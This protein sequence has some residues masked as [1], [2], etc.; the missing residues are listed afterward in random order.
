MAKKP[1]IK[2]T[3][4]DELSERE[5]ADLFVSYE[6]DKNE[7][8]IYKRGF[9]TI[10]INSEYERA[11]ELNE[12]VEKIMNRRSLSH[13]TEKLMEVFKELAGKKAYEIFFYIWKNWQAERR[14]EKMMQQAKNILKQAEKRGTFKIAKTQEE[15]INMV[16]S[17]GRESPYD[18]NSMKRNSFIVGYMLALEDVKKQISKGVKHE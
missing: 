16:C 6:T 17:M 8:V 11:I 13:D 5:I 7:F 10:L 15:L 12:L 3:K 2:F 9:D 1:I 14:K 4:F 18:W